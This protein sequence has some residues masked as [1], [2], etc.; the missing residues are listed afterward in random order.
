MNL[1][2]EGEMRRL[3]EESPWA[4]VDQTSEIVKGGFSSEDDARAWM[5]TPEGKKTLVERGGSYDIEQREAF[6]DIYDDEK[7]D[8]DDVSG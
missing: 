8:A 2:P 5:D 4:V 1:E 3:E 7:K 6:Q